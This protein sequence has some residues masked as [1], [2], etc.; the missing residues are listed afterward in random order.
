MSRPAFDRIKAKVAE[1]NDAAWVHPRD[2]HA[3]ASTVPADQRSDVVKALHKGTLVQAMDENRDGKAPHP[4]VLV[5]T[6]D[7]KHLLGAAEKHLTGPADGNA[8]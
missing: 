5:H 2:V 7:L 1:G 6:G 4:N 3:L 8:G